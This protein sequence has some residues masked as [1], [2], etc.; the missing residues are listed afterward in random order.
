M[1]MEFLLFVLGILTGILILQFYK[2]Y[3]LTKSGERCNRKD[4]LKELL[5]SSKD[6][7]YHFQF[8]PH[9]EYLYLSPSV[10]DLLGPG[11]WEASCQNLYISYE[12]IHPEDQDILIKKME[13]KVDYSK[14]ILQRWRDHTG[15]YK[16]CEEYATPIYENGELMAMVGYIRDIS[17]KVELQQELQYL[18]THDLLTGTYNRNYFEEMKERYNH[19]IDSAISLILCDLDELKMVN[20]TFGHVEGDKMIQQAAKLINEFFSENAIVA[21]VGGDE[22]VIVL[23][24]HQASQVELLCNEFESKIKNYN[25]EAEVRQIGLSLGYA[26][27]E[28]SIGN[29]NCLFTEADKRM[30]QNKNA[31]R[32]KQPVLPD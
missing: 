16:W 19:E 14:P 22:F 7:I 3:L 15:N 26:S 5:D 31:K 11:V 25:E 12:R 27:T 18:S 13:G 9:P 4:H 32:N 23:P 30:Y 24:D 21:R 6:V 17:E 10:D 29:M 8:K 2:R 28:R 20:D 1:K